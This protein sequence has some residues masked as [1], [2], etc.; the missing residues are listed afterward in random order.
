MNSFAW[1]AQQIS[2]ATP[3]PK[4]DRSAKTREKLLTWAVDIG[5]PF[6][7]KQA[8]RWLEVDRSHAHKII[9]RNVQLGFLQMAS[10][11]GGRK[12]AA[13]TPTPFAR[14]MFTR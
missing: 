6:H 9:R 3:R 13:F 14:G 2:S 8:Q 11:G 4:F 7:V 12:A 10:E 5:Q 1:T